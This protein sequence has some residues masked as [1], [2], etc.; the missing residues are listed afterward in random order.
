[1]PPF[2]YNYEAY[3]RGSISARNG[4]RCEA[5]FEQ[6]QHETQHKNFIEMVHIFTHNQS[7]KKFILTTVITQKYI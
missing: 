3:K 5:D 4:Q 1:M 7:I 6:M 2:S